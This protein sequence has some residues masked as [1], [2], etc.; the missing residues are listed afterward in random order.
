MITKC[1]GPR[2]YFVVC[3]A[4][5]NPSIV[6]YIFNQ[7]SIGNSKQVETNKILL[8]GRETQVNNRRETYIWKSHHNTGLPS[9]IDTSKEKLPLDERFDRC[10]SENFL[11]NLFKGIIFGAESG[12]VR[13]VGEILSKIFGDKIK[14]M[15]NMDNLQGFYE[16]AKLIQ[17]H[18]NKPEASDEYQQCVSPVVPY[19]L[20]R[21]TSNVEFGRQ[22]LNGVNCVFV[23]RCTKLPPNFPVTQEMVKHF[24]VRSGDLEKEMEVIS[25]FYYN[26]YIYLCMFLS[27]IKR[28]RPF[29]TIKNTLQ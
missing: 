11:G 9:S 6:N 29:L 1:S 26:T 7:I 12:V 20:A 4:T 13:V 8:E 25:T 17:M 14:D 5:V 27:E 22:I 2:F 15:D 16:A 24:L 18:D 10:K 21:W 3:G 23:K 19:E 28:K